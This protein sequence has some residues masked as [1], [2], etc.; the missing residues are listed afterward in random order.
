LGERVLSILVGA[1][2]LPFAELILP[3]GLTFA[4]TATQLG[5]T[6]AL[7]AAGA[8]H[9]FAVVQSTVLVI[10]VGTVLGLAMTLGLLAATWG[11]VIAAAAEALLVWHA[12]A[13][14]T[15]PSRAPSLTI[16]R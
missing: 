7:R 15:R 12:F 6:L 4:L 3:V 9:V 8:G 14:S 2:W 16:A 10:R 13:K 5:P 1:Q 11:L